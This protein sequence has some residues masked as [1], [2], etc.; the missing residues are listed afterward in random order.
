[1]NDVSPPPSLGAQLDKLWKGFQSAA[2]AFNASIEELRVTA[3]QCRWLWFVRPAHDKAT[4][5]R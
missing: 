2:G 3:T 4:M 5:G 1:M